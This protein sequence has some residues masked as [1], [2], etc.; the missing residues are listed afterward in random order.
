M[1]TLLRPK[2][3]LEKERQRYLAEIILKDLSSKIHTG[4]PL[5]WSLF[6]KIAKIDFRPATLTK[7]ASIK[8]V[9]M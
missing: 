7:E 8:E 1:K 6:N 3:L 5:W 2:T 9:F 4:K